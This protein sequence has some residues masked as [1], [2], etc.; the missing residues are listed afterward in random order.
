ML[1]VNITNGNGK[2]NKT[3]VSNNNA[4]KVATLQYYNYLNEIRYFLNPTYGFNMNINASSN[5]DELIHNGTDDIAW[6]GYSITGTTVTFDSITEPLSGAKHIAAISM[7]NDSIFRFIK[8]SEIN[9]NDYIALNGYI[10]LIDVGG[11]GSNLFISAYNTIDGIS[12]GDEVSIASYINPGNIGVYQS[13]TIPLSDMNLTNENID[14]FSFTVNTDGIPPSFYLDN[15][16][17]TSIGSGFG[18]QIFTLRPNKD[19]ILIINSIN[20]FIVD[21]YDGLTGQ[22][23]M[24]KLEYNKILGEILSNG[25]VYQRFQDKNI[26]FSILLKDISNWLTAPNTTIENY[27]SNGIN[28]IMNIHYNFFEPYVMTYNDRIIHI[29][30]DNMSGFINFRV[31]VNCKRM[32][33]NTGN[34]YESVNLF[35]YGS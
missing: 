12:I 23:G 18:P 20:W 25:I 21:D 2:K 30:N 29:V 6:T 24:M 28:T 4:L 9:L 3:E 1:N 32:I 35:S 5:L 10:N 15:I 8:N 17:L 7:A 14:S 33:G 27:S 34:I 19:E 16:Y 22:S 31:S 13:F 26:L 11:P